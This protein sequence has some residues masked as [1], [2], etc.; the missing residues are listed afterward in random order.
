MSIIDAT[1]VLLHVYFFVLLSGGEQRLVALAYHLFT[2][3]DFYGF[4]DGKR[5][6]NSPFEVFSGVDEVGYQ[7]AKNAIDIRLQ[8]Y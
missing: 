6:N 7:L 5:Y 1:D 2:N 4:E 8:F 3:Q